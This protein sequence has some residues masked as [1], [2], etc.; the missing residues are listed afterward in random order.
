MPIGQNDTPDDIAGYLAQNIEALRKKRQLTQAQLAK[1]ADLPRSTLTY[2]ESGAGNPS[3]QNLVRIS[4]ALQVSIE[5][6][7]SAPR[8]RTKL[9]KAADVTPNRKG[10]ALVYDLLPDPIPGMHIDRLELEP[11][12]RMAGVPHTSGT[13][14]YL[15]PLQGEV[16]VRVSGGTFVVERGDVFAFPGDQPHSYHNSGNSRAVCI[17]VVVVAPPGV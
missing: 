1:L 3:L 10:A 6:L 9:I 8:T 14:E 2:L 16:T 11:G 5:E 15:T 13:K 7:L 12:A 4:A 17:S